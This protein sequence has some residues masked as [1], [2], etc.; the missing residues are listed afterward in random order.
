MD[1]M[2]WQGSTGPAFGRPALVLLM[3]ALVPLTV[4]GCADAGQRPIAPGVASAVSTSASSEPEVAPSNC[5]LTGDAVKF[6]NINSNGAEQVVRAIVSERGRLTDVWDRPLKPVV[7]GGAPS[8]W[9]PILVSS[10]MG[11]RQTEA[12]PIEVD[13]QDMLD[14]LGSD[15]QERSIVWASVNRFTADF[16]VSCPGGVVRGSVLT[17]ETNSIGTTRCDWTSPQSPDAVL[18]QLCASDLD[19]GDLHEPLLLG[20]AEVS[21]P[22]QNGVG[23]AGRR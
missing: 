18:H 13:R 1:S 9:L 3:V 12:K 5:A 11:G 6:S 4:S 2:A 23:R 22:D 15:Q 17:W 20:P 14:A 7:L 19:P 10:L 16:V 21:R 8:S